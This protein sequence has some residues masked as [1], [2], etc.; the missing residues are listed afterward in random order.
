[1]ALNMAGIQRDVCVYGLG[2][3]EEGGGRWKSK[4]RKKEER[5]E[6]GNKNKELADTWI[7]NIYNLLTQS[8]VYVSTTHLV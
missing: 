1:M 7:D 2:G 8:P 3:R 6:K 5:R 4:R